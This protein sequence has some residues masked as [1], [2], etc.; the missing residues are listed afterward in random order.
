M[1]TSKGY[2]HCGF[3]VIPYDVRQTAGVGAIRNMAT[4]DL[5]GCRGVPEDH[6]NTMV[7]QT[8]A[9]GAPLSLSL[10][11]APQTPTISDTG[12]LEGPI[13]GCLGG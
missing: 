13:F 6:I 4:K 12:A 1:L 3:H 8:M 2:P 11:L 10:I 7:L 9:S 5:A